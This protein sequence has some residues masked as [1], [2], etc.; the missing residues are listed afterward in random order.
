MSGNIDRI[1]EHA[2]CTIHPPLVA[3]GGKPLIEVGDGGKLFAVSH[4]SGD[5]AALRDIGQRHVRKNGVALSCDVA[6]SRLS[7]FPANA[8]EQFFAVGN[9]KHR[10]RCQRQCG[11][12]AVFP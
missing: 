11:R 3:I 12:E 6:R 8:G 10:E 5:I 7:L 1:G 4:S 2:L 9:R